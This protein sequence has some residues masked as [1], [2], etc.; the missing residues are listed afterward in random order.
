[1]CCRRLKA[2]ALMLCTLSHV[3]A[4]E[5]IYKMK[6]EDDATGLNKNVSYLMQIV[7]LQSTPCALYRTTYFDIAVKVKK[8]RFRV[9][10]LVE[11]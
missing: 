7:V 2:L 5:E 9:L 10:M 4:F 11:N 3:I 8:C 1:M 6:I